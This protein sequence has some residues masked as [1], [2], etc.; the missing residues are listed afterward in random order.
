M[1]SRVAFAAFSH[2]LSLPPRAHE[3]LNDISNAMFA[4]SAWNNANPLSPVTDDAWNSAQNFTRHFLR[5]N[6]YFIPETLLTL[7]SHQINLIWDHLYST[8]TDTALRKPP[9][10]LWPGNLPLEDAIRARPLP[11]TPR[12]VIEHLRTFIFDFSIFVSHSSPSCLRTKPANFHTA[13][14]ARHSLC[15][16]HGR[17]IIP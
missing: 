7:I 10:P 15:H 5:Q 17:S 16:A 11:N 13:K 14:M 3:R 1:G 4:S 8:K 9:E 2:S 12:V 6:P